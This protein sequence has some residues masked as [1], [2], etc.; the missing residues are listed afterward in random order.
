MARKV[1]TLS[2]DVDPGN[3]SLGRL[4][5][6]GTRRVG[7]SCRASLAAR[8]ETGPAEQL[9]P[10]P[11]DRQ[12]VRQT[13]QLQRLSIQTQ[14][15]SGLTM[16]RVTA[17]RQAG[18]HHSRGGVEIEMQIDGIDQEGGGPVIRPVH[19]AWGGRRIVAL[20]VGH[21]V[22]RLGKRGGV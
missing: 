1:R 21:S 18:A 10:L 14:R 15:R 17:Q 13:A 19:G 4:D 5:H 11:D 3:D 9:L 16:S 20:A 8:L 12:P 6:E 2:G 22:L 7:M